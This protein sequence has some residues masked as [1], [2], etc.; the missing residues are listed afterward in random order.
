MATIAPCTQAPIRQFFDSVYSNQPLVVKVAKVFFVCL[1]AVVSW[2]IFRAIKAHYAPLEGTLEGTLWIYLRSTGSIGKDERNQFAKTLKLENGVPLKVAA[3]DLYVQT[4]ILYKGQDKP[5]QPDLPSSLFVQAR[6][7]KEEDQICFRRD[8]KLH[9]LT[10]VPLRQ[11]SKEITFEDCLRNV[12]DE[13]HWSKHEFLYEEDVP[14]SYKRWSLGLAPVFLSP[15]TKQVI[16][17]QK[18]T[19][20]IDL[21][22]LQPVSTAKSLEVLSSGKLPEQ[23]IFQY[24]LAASGLPNITILVDR[25]HLYVH[26]F[27]EIILNKGE[28]LLGGGSLR[29]EYFLDSLLVEDGAKV[30]MANIEAALDDGGVLTI[31]IPL[32]QEGEL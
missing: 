30:D 31:N 3:T 29:K 17:G 24:R 18:G 32:I 26:T 6:Q 10:L 23:N 13:W 28:K 7:N 19:L 9:R 1:A 22:T 4:K 15:E 16:V 21:D 5:V 25:Q 27:R 20:P 2:V 14:D 12:E 11:N 8:G